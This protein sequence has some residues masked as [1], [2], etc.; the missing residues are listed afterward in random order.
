VSSKSLSTLK[1]FESPYIKCNGG[2]DKGGTK[3]KVP[4]DIIL[5][6]A[7]TLFEIG[8]TPLLTK[9]QNPT[10]YRNVA[11]GGTLERHLHSFFLADRLSQPPKLG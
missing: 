7:D 4:F 5:P 11:T 1:T 3:L 9:S 6:L 10:I 2:N 8:T